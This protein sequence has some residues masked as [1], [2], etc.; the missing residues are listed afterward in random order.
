MTLIEFDNTQNDVNHIHTVWHDLERNFGQDLLR[1][2]YE[3]GS[4]AH[5]HA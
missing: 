2:H 5:H 4:H 3:S 1:A